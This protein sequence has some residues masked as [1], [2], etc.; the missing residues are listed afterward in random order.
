MA[1]LFPFLPFM[2]DETLLSWAARLANF[3]TRGRLVP[4]LHDIGLQLEDLLG[5]ASM[6]IERLC[7]VTGQEIAP[8]RHNAA[9]RDSHRRYALRGEVFSVELLTG[10]ATSFCPLCLAGDEGAG[11][12]PN[13]WRR[14]RLTWALRTTRTCPIHHL[15]LLERK[16]DSWDDVAHELSVKVPET[17][18]ALLAMADGLN[19]R[20]PSP[21]QTYILD[22]FEG[23]G[24]PAWLDGQG[25]EQAARATEMLGAV[26]A[27]GPKANRASLSAS[28]WDDAGR[29]GWEWTQ[30]GEAG[31]REALA[32]LQ[33]EANAAREGRPL[34]HRSTFGMLYDWLNSAKLNKNPGPIRDVVR[35]F[36]ISTSDIGSSAK[37]MG[38]VVECRQFYSVTSLA[39]CHFI[40]PLTLRSVLIARGILPPGA[41]EQV[42]SSLV[43]PAAVGEEIAML[44]KRAIPVADVPNIL[45]VSRPMVQALIEV[46]LLHRLRG[47]G[48]KTGKLSC[49]ID[50]A[51][52]EE[53]ELD[54]ERRATVVE[55]SPAGMV[56]LAKAAE[57][58]RRKLSVI[59]KLLFTGKLRRI[60]R[61]ASQKGLG[62][63]LVDPFELRWMFGNIRPGMSA[64]CAFLVLGVRRGTGEKLIG[65]F[66]GAPLL[67]TISVRNFDGKWVTPAALDKFR[68]SY[69][70]AKQLRVETSLSVS[71]IDQI[72]RKHSVEPA[73][74]RR[75]LG[76]RLYRRADIPAICFREA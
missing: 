59:V 74:D 10:R 1:H 44:I 55:D 34:G 6:A 52:L 16:L 69:M 3:H 72:L 30:N 64:E 2:Q 8:L 41:S 15:P 57:L 13:A 9:Q 54:L 21:L 58:S 76:A 29:A 7:E 48:F 47:D 24:G 71:K 68:R 53:L 39:K 46:G 31:I 19:T 14:G 37:L 73:F 43:V 22:R 65:D 18:D 28:D 23:Q 70:T 42:C 62:G 20:T 32:H 60:Y 33:D 75:E 17:G 5:G 38:Q 67:E 35:D 56:S 40:N 11:A 50:R 51:E 66:A 12:N 45:G 26:M 49:A 61:L 63:I 27:F 36:I 4:F 25:V